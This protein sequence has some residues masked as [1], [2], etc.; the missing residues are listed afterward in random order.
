M[1]GAPGIV[2][3]TREAPH[4]PCRVALSN[5]TEHDCLV[6][7]GD[8]EESLHAVADL[9]RLWPLLG[10]PIAFHRRLVDLTGS[11]K[12]SLMLS[13]AIYWMRHGK[14]IRQHDGWFF[15]TMEQW[16]WETGLSRHEQAHARARL[17]ELK[18][19]QERTQRLP[20]TLHFRVDGEALAA[21]L[22]DRLGRRYP[23]IVWDDDALVA[24][25]LGP[26]LP[27]HRALTMLTADVNAALF[28]SRALYCV[29]RILRQ[30]PNAW[31]QT[32][33]AQ[34]QADAGFSRREQ[35]T[36]RNSLRRLGIIEEMHKG[37]P[38][39]RWARVDIGRLIELL[40]EASAG[41]KSELAQ[42]H[43]TG[44]QGCG[45][46]TNSIGANR[47]TS[48][49]DSHKQY[50]RKPANLIAEN[51][52]NCLPVSA[53]LYKDL[54]TRTMTTQPP[55]IAAANETNR[56]MVDEPRGGGE[57]IFPNA[58]LPEE[59]PAAQALVM[60]CPDL[61]QALLD[62]LAGRMSTNAIR[63]SPIGYLRGMVQR[64]Q[65]G[66]FVLELGVRIAT[67]RRQ[68]EEAEV[69]RQ[70]QARD[71][72][73]L[74]AERASPEYQARVAQRRAEIRKILDAMP[75]TANGSKTP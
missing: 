61:A 65:A 16:R 32:S 60:R 62:E 14:D 22:S 39:R 47:Q 23:C 30:S 57:L 55:P 74:R 38:P 54:I 9:A 25:L 11:I 46:P 51:R 29:R 66:N 37:I 34:W 48:M 72:L 73:N 6:S 10:R 31:F 68:R 35:E 18:V 64:A 70:K 3:T 13:Q 7:M 36:A 2:A 21:L 33:T 71:D 24:E 4:Q 43:K 44:K 59:R 69:L 40:S 8:P 17:R 20:A 75:K 12:A 27:F 1:D 45:I 42:L 19:L 67:G 58:L 56:R 49:W 41:G 28:L 50:W 26:V 5:D 53:N 63:A 52:H 15:K